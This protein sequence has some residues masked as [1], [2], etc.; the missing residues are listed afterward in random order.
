[1]EEELRALYRLQQIDLELDELND[2]GS[3]LTEDIGT[4]ERKVNDLTTLL[5]TEEAKLKE[6]RASR[7]V[8]NQK[9]ADLRERLLTLNE[10]LRTVRNNKEYE[11]TT[12]EI[13]A[14]EQEMGVLER[15]LVTGNTLEA[16]AIREIEAI[17]KQREEA[18][19]ELQEKTETLRS[20]QETHADELGELRASRGETLGQITDDVM[21]RYE[22]VRGAHPDAV[23]RVR[24]G[25]CSGCYRA[26]PPQMLVEMRRLERLFICEHCGRIVIDEDVAA[27][28]TVA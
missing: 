15:T 16:N 14:T 7:A 11:A 26:L 6:I 25:A 22:F 24:K 13:A 10:R 18:Q 12:N 4:L 9:V 3:D 1:V 19:V 23:V 5:T 20:I 8:E 2:G 21:R 17:S 28:V 27:S